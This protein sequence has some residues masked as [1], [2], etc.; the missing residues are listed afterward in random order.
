MDLELN[1]GT[2]SLMFD[3]KLPKSKR[4]AALLSALDV[5]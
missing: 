1:G 3:S 5:Q 2:D 4:P